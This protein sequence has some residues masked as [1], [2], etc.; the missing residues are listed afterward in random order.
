MRAVPRG[1]DI[2]AST[3]L[4]A[5]A[6][7]PVGASWAAFVCLVP[8][9]A[10]IRSVRDGAASGLVLGILICLLVGRW[11]PESLHVFAPDLPAWST[12][13]VAAVWV[14]GAGFML[15]GMTA[16]V[17]RTSS[18]GARAIAIAGAVCAVDTLHSYPSYGVPWALLGH[19]QAGG[20]GVAQLAVIGG[21]PLVS[22][23]CAALN[24]ALAST[25]GACN[26]A[27]T[28]N[29]TCVALGTILALAVGGLSVCE[30]ARAEK[31]AGQSERVLALQLAIPREERW[32]ASA[33][34]RH[35]ATALEVAR[36]ILRED[37]I[38]VDAVVFPETVVTTPWEKDDRFM[39]E[40]G[41]FENETSVPVALGLT[42]EAGDPGHAYRNSFVLIGTDGD[43]QARV[44][45]AVGIPFIET[46]PTGIAQTLWP[47]VGRLRSGPSMETSDE[48]SAV[49]GE[50][51]FLPLLCYEVMFAS[52]AQDRRPAEI[53]AILNLADD[54]W[55]EGDAASRQVIAAASFRAVEQRSSLVRVTNGG[56]SAAIDPYG[57]TV[58]KVPFGVQGYFVATVRP[59]KPP[60]FREGS[61]LVGLAML[62]A[63]LGSRFGIATN[64]R[65]K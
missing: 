14:K 38:P 3:L 22:A 17:L 28:W 49:L 46:I 48:T 51:P 12:W 18:A 57:R 10:R 13:A 20:T 15:V 43:L 52:L 23:A 44:D 58:Q 31:P 65:I 30:H 63:L 19:S 64:R 39:R 32:L 37:Q 8:W 40:V 5:A 27:K 7:E 35:L 11:I 25:C 24:S 6:Q 61:A 45:K 34:I 4:Y 9:L 55:T 50:S 33:Q 29:S 60:G 36:R 2:V 42:F 26:S 16:G 56:I 59:E 54:S 47:F 1:V 53:L 41:K 62:G 21:V